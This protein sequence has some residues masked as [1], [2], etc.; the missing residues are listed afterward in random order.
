MLV[1]HPSVLLVGGLVEELL[2]TVSHGKCCTLISGELGHLAV[3][4]LVK[5]FLRYILML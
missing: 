1:A 3:I 4:F 5:V 2:L